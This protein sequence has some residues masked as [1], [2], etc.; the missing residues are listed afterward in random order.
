V[1]ALLPTIDAQDAEGWAECFLPDGALEFD[2]HVVGGHAALREYAE[3][4]TRC[5]APAT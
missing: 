3:A 4:H 2:G 5:C 1:L